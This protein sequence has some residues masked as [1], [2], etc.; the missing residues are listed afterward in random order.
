VLQL[1]PGC[2]CCDRDLPGDSP[3]AMICS[4]ECTFC[5]ACAEGRLGGR[6]PNCGGE[7]V[8][9]PIRPADALSSV[10]PAR[11]QARRLPPR[12][13][14]GSFVDSP[15]AEP[16]R[17]NAWATLRLLEAGRAL[18][19]EQL[20]ATVPGT[21][22]SVLATLQHIIRSESFYQFLLSGRW[23]AWRWPEDQSPDLDTLERAAQ[24]S[25]AFWETFLSEPYDPDRPVVAPDPREDKTHD[26]ALGVIL[27]QVLD[28]GTDHRSQISTTLTA[29]G[30]TP[31]RLDAWAYGRAHGRVVTRPPRA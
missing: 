11:V 27:T 24:E 15:L 7:L 29:I 10:D 6:C 8:R 5:R 25:A 18:T 1:R 4:F 12:G 14:D 22:G 20:A 21:F 13:V 28:H 3:D 30:V 26:V 23:P 17:H 31:P 19:L 9:R 2:E 16:L